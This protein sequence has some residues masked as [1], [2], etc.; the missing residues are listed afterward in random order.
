M[1]AIYGPAMLSGEIVFDVSTAPD[2]A[3]DAVMV[4]GGYV[5]FWDSALDTLSGVWLCSFYSRH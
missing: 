4:V 1:N 3:F 2:L 5:A